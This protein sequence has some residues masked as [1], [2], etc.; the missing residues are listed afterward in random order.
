MFKKPEIKR[1]I[2]MVGT[3][4][5]G[6]T[7]IFEVLSVHPDLGWLSNYNKLLP[8]IGFISVMPRIYNLPFFSRLNRGQK[9]QYNQGRRLFNFLLPTPFECYW[10]WNLLC[11]EFEFSFLK[12]KTASEKEKKKVRKAVRQILFWQDKKRFAAKITGPTRMTFLKSIFPD[13]V[14]VHIKR[15]PQAVILSFVDSGF[16]K[17]GSKGALPRWED[18]LPENWKKEWEHYNKSELALMSIQYRSIMQVCEE[19][20]RRLG[21]NDYTEIRYEDFIDNPLET[22]RRICSFCNLPQSGKVEEFLKQQNYING[23]RK[24]LDNITPEQ[25]KVIDEILGK[26]R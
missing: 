7:I 13:A 17:P 25:Q 9:K 4:R 6:S 1:P 5:C 21:K 14:F 15:D 18:G 11:D 8:R 2:F 10:K 16:W 20:K 24:Y 26:W 23:N 12:D 19:E 22:I 3:G